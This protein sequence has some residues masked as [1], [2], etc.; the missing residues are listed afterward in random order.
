M[1]YFIF[2]T[3]WNLLKQKTLD[4]IIVLGLFDLKF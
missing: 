2:I 3:K 4:G 1:S